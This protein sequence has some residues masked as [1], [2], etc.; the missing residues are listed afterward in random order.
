MGNKEINYHGILPQEQP[1]KTFVFVYNLRVKIDVNVCNNTI[2][3]GINSGKVIQA[4]SA[5]VTT[6]LRR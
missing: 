6:S 3:N 2:S 4:S 1:P 5:H